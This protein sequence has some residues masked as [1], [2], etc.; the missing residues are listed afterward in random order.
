M[1]LAYI[2]RRYGF[3]TISNT[4]PDELASKQKDTPKECPFILVS[5]TGICSALQGFRHGNFAQRRIYL[6]SP[7]EN[8]LSDGFVWYANSYSRV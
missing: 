8:K 3:E 7:L 2:D 6:H 1:R 4:D 5:R